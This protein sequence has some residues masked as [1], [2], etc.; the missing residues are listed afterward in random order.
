MPDKIF[1]SLIALKSTVMLSNFGGR[2]LYAVK[3]TPAFRNKHFVHGRMPV[4]Y[5]FEIQEKASVTGNTCD[6]GYILIDKREQNF[7]RFGAK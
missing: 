3:I 7:S 4:A 6:I 5:D 2:V 1:L